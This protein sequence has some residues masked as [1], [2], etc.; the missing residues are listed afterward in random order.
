MTCRAY[1]ARERHRTHRHEDARKNCCASRGAH[2]FRTPGAWAVGALA[3]MSLSSGL[4]FTDQFQV[5]EINKKLLPNI[6]SVEVEEANGSLVIDSS[7]I[8]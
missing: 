3:A 6:H 2:S 8:D 7:N 1:H 4:L 5:K